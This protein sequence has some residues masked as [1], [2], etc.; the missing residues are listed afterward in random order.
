M[1]AALEGSGGM[2]VESGDVAALAE[3]LC[4][5]LQSVGSR[6]YAGSRFAVGS[7]AQRLES[8]YRFGAAHRGVAEI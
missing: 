5:S 8:V 3:G 7:S 6:R 1:P 2:L 4:S